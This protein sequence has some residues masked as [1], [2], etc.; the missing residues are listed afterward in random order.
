MEYQYHGRTGKEEKKT[1][2]K[3]K[4]GGFSY[5]SKIDVPGETKRSETQDM[6]NVG[7]LD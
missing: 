6:E 4:G 2:R 1:R 3:R 7:K 5:L